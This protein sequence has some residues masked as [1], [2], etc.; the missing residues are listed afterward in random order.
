MP[1]T[2][3][4][5]LARWAHRGAWAAVVI[6]LL[7]PLAAF[8]AD[9]GWGQEVRILSA[10]EPSVV[11]LNRALWTPGDPVA[12]IYGNPMSTSTRVL[13]TSHSTVLHP[14]EDP[15]LALLPVAAGGER[16][17]QVQTLWWAVRLGAIGAGAATVV[18]LALAYFLRRRQRATVPAPSA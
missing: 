4:A 2:R 18:L 5:S 3:L 1:A 17:L 8:L 13:L 15:S 10:H 6:A 7:L 9:R 11:E 12:E 14:Q 16:P